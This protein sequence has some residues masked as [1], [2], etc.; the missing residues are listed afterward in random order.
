MSP[1]II[2]IVPGMAYANTLRSHLTKECTAGMRISSETILKVAIVSFDLCVM[3]QQI[4]GV[5]ATGRA[6]GEDAA[7]IA[8]IVKMT[9][10]MMMAPLLI[11]LG[12]VVS[13]LS[14]MLEKKDGKRIVAG[15]TTVDTSLLTLAMTVLSPETRA[16]KSRQAGMK[17]VLL[18]LMLFAWLQGGRLFRDTLIIG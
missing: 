12:L 8:L 14:R 18:A 9:R 17:P 7:R 10:V 5:G 4:G 1:V 3:L 11:I 15:I 2:G 6:V 16:A 13:S